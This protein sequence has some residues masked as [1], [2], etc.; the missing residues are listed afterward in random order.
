MSRYAKRLNDQKPTEV[1][2]NNNNTVRCPE[3]WVIKHVF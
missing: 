1:E 3:I 2:K